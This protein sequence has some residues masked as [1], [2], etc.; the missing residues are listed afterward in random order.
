MNNI[1]AGPV[2]SKRRI[3]VLFHESDKH[4]NLSNFV[5]DHLA[6]FWREEG[7]EVVY[8]F[9]TRRFVPAELVFVHVNLSVVPEKYLEF[10]ARYP[11]AV[12]ARIRDIRK[13]TT[14][15]NLLCLGDAWDGQVI[16]K[17]NLNY[18]GE[19]ER[20]LGRGLLE[21]KFPFWGETKKLASRILDRS[22]PFASWRDYLIFDRLVDVP[23]H[24]FRNSEAVVERFRPELEG[25]LYHLRMFQFLGERWSCVRIASPEP[26]LKA[27]RS[28]SVENIEPSPDIV[29]WRKALDIDYGKLDYVINEGQVVLLDVN[30]TT[31][32]SRHIPDDQLRVSRRYQAEGLYSYFS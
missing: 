21:R 8:L 23:E 32:A 4:T 27:Q 3:V 22:A 12:N 2:R 18:A 16:V 24:W 28:I 20:A 29:A 10:A 5:V 17:S 15:R 1:V 6:G 11:I 14:S 26:V 30:K 7:H 19:P 13:S 9:G 25:G 31:G